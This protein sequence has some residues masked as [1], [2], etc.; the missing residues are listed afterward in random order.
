MEGLSKGAV[1]RLGKRLRDAE[2]PDP[3]DVSAYVE[4]S[5]TFEEVLRETLL[6]VDEASERADVSLDEKTSRIKQLYSIVAKLRRGH[7]RMSSIDDIA[8][9]RAVVQREVDVNALVLQLATSRVKRVRD[10]RNFDRNGYRAV[11]LTLVDEAGRGVELQ[12]RT[13]IQHAWAGLCE[14]RAA[15][16]DHA[17]KYGGGPPTE[18]ELLRRLSNAGRALD[19][20]QVELDAARTRLDLSTVAPRVAESYRESAERALDVEQAQV[21]EEVDRFI[22]VC[23]GYASTESEL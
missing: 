2:R 12:L 13:E 10:Y 18:Q 3:A 19:L 15:V 21:R 14:R 4:W 7:P 23:G 11:H 1:D 5:A 17:V 6:I 20:R 8:G 16:V 22:G 9:C